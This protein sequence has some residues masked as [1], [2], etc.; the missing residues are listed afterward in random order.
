MSWWDNE[1]TQN[2]LKKKYLHDGES[3]IHDLI[4]RVTSI[5]SDDIKEEVKEAMYNGDF[6]PA[7][8]TLYAAGMKGKSHLVPTNCYI[9][10][11]IHDSLE[12]IYEIDY[13]MSKIGALGGG[14]GFAL[15]NIRPKGTKINNSAKISDGVVFC[16]KKYN[17]TGENIGQGQRRMAMMAMLSCEHPDIEEFLRI[18]AGGE[19][20]SAMNLSIKFTDSFLFAVKDNKEL[21]LRFIVESTGEQVNKTINARK[22]FGEFCEVNR[23]YGEPGCIFIDRVQSYH[24]LSEYDDYII[25]T[26]NPCSEL[27]GIGGNSCNLG[28]INLYN[29]VENKFTD[30]AYINYDKLKQLV[31]LGVRTLDEILDYGYD[32]QPFDYHRKCIDDW[33][34]IGLGVFGLADM[35]IA[36]KQKYGS[37]ESID[38][39]SKLFK[40]IFRNALLASSELAKQKG[41]FGKY[42]NWKITESEILNNLKD[43]KIRESITKNGLRNG[44]L[45]VIA[46]TGTLSMFMGSC[47]GGVE[48]IFK[49][50]YT[51]TTHAG[52]NKGVSFKVFSKSVEDL[53]KFNNLPLTLSDDEIK[54]KFPWIVESHDIDPI[55]RIKVQAAMQEF[56]DVAI[57]STINLRKGTSA[58][59]I[60]DIYLK[61][62]EYGLKGVTVF[63]DGCKRGNL[64]GVDTNKQPEIAYNTIEPLKR[65]GIKAING[66]TFRTKTAC[67]KLYLTVNK[68]DD[69]D[70]FEVFANP[71]GGCTA[72]INSMCR[73]VSMALRSGIKVESIIEELSAIKCSACQYMIR[74]GDKDIELSCG[75]AIANALK[76]A[77]DNKDVLSNTTNIDNNVYE[78]EEKDDGLMVC[79]ECGQKSMRRVAKCSSCVCGFSIC[80]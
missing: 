17:N 7:G 51:R 36:L 15:D 10:P 57:S 56:V 46:P 22:F 52:E 78:V 5:F 6:C 9:M 75:N 38:T 76:S 26:S 43:D 31:V 48:P 54:A 71:T 49:C 21:N 16:L 2:I 18:K 29:C 25:E 74:K 41:S 8:R 73:L 44:T 1:I 34:S 19:K 4:N 20:L 42:N 30:D 67:S 47:S 32:M 50:S 61:A 65:R 13:Q 33:R 64:L 79:P 80:D 14:T 45:L 23:D 28:S 68:T 39:T 27:V 69:G 77:Y 66:T 59:K 60:F 53:L 24:L 11:T 63:V 37:Q 70:V 62:W 35:F 12:S 72:S 3:T 55:D 40:F 58:D